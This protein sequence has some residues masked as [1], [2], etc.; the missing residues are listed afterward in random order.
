M[1]NASGMI[2]NGLP[3]AIPGVLVRN[4]KDEPALR[5]KMGEDAVRRPR[6]IVSCAALHTSLGAPDEVF[7]HPQEVRPGTGPALDMASMIEDW[8]TDHR[9]AGA[10]AG[11]GADGTVYCFAD[12]LLEE[13]FHAK[14]VNPL[15]IGIEYQQG[16][17]SE[18]YEV[19]IEAGRRV[20]DWIT[21]YFS[22][23]R[24]TPKA[25]AGAP[26][27]RLVAGARDFVGVFGHRDQDSNR[28]A[29]DPGDAIMASLRYPALDIAGGQDLELW[30]RRQAWLGLAAADCDGIPGP[31]TIAALRARGFVSGL[32]A[33]PPM[34][35]RMP[36]ELNP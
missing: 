6:P 9:C 7:K 8:N 31:H 20:V 5:I 2:V 33:L 28:G 12:L 10:H 17:E 34:G 21:A 23:Q 22:I 4:W 16:R 15:S 18:L 26:L 32:W 19:Q 1:S 3:V 35:L 11:I 27:A 13:T 24:Q 14:S 29:G 36:A 25:Y 30:K